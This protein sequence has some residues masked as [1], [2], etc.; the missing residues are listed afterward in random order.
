MLNDGQAEPREVEIVRAV[1]DLLGI[2][3]AISAP[4]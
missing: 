4:R 2:S 3:F 1:S